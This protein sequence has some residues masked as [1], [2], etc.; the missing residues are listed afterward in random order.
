MRDP[1]APASLGLVLLVLA[2]L[3]FPAQPGAAQASPDPQEPKKGGA[4]EGGPAEPPAAESQLTIEKAL[5]GVAVKP[6]LAGDVASFSYAFS[7]KS[8]REFLDWVWLKKPDRAGPSESNEGASGFSVGAGGSNW[9]KAVH[10]VE[11][12]PPCS[13][14]LNLKCDYNGPTSNLLATLCEPTPGKGLAVD[15]GRQ[16]VRK[17]G[18]PARVAGPPARA[19][20]RSGRDYTIRVEVRDGEVTANFNGVETLRAPLTEKEMAPGKIGFEIRDARVIFT[21]IA[22]QGRVSLDWA[23]KEASKA[24]G[25][26]KPKSGGTH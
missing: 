19:E 8:G 25:S 21:T 24:D 4:G 12:A 5:A 3:A 7:P 26:K 6:S 14:E 15:W 18:K 20:I 10:K 11:F 16:L 22:L 17:G 2:S 23:E 1:C 13:I 9:G